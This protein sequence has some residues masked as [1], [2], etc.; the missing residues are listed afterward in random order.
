MKIKNNKYILALVPSQHFT[1]NVTLYIYDI[2]NN[3]KL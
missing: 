3:E 2:Y 1:K